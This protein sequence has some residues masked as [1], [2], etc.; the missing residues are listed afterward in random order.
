MERSGNS[1]HVDGGLVN[2]PVDVLCGHSGSDLLCDRVKARHIDH[3]TL[4]DPVHMFLR[5]EQAVVRNDRACKLEL[6]ELFI[7]AHMAGLVFAPASAPAG[8]I[9]FH[10]MLSEMNHCKSFL[11]SEVITGRYAVYY[12]RLRHYF[13]L[14]LTATY[15]IPFSC[16][17]VYLRFAR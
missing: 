15:R 16:Q 3:R 2:D 14:S 12:S 17:T 6:S 1:A 4:F 9:A 7:K 8:I 13:Y 11:S 5:L 10:L